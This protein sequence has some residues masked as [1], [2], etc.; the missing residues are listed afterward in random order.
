MRKY[1]PCH[2]PA[3]EPWNEF[4]QIVVPTKYRPQILS[5]AH[6]HINGHLGI[7]KTYH[8]I[9]RHFFWPKLKK[10]V[11]ECCRVCHE[12]Q[13]T[14]KPNQILKPA[15]LVPIPICDEPFSKV[16]IDCVGPLPRTR[17]GNQFLLTICAQPPDTQ[18][19]YLCEEQQV[20]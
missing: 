4:H 8:K 3:D 20:N 12:C 6:N 2:I 10:D 5:L 17:N 13:I 19:Q 16:I 9:L 15:P 11:T 7:A 18:K 14:G 1:T